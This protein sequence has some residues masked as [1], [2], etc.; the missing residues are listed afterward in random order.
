MLQQ[1]VKM[2]EADKETGDA[3]ANLMKQFINEG[4]VQADED[5]SFIIP[6]LDVDKKFK[7]FEED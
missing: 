3:A 4:F 7:P 1:K 2:M 5:G 6:G